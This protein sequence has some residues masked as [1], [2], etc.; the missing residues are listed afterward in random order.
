M[1]GEKCIALKIMRDVVVGNSV[2]PV[3]G[4]LQRTRIIMPELS[5]GL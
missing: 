1:P 4:Q 3:C 2:L 5:A